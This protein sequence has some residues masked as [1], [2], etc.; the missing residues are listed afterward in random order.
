MVDTD[1]Q[2]S[3]DTTAS[4]N[5]LPS[6]GCLLTVTLLVI[7][8]S[9]CLWI[10]WRV[11]SQQ[12]RLEYL[13]ELQAR[14][15][16]EPAKPAWLHDLVV[17]T[18]GEE[19]AAGLSNITSVNLWGQPVTDTGLEHLSGCTNLESLDLAHTQITDVGLQHL[20]GLTNLSFLAL[21]GTE[22]TDAGL[23][24]LSGLTNLE[25]LFLS[26]TQVSDP[27]LQHLSRLTSL[28]ELWLT[29][30]QIT[31]TGFEHLSGTDQ[32]GKSSISARHRSQTPVCST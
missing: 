26:D 25:T 14:F 17:A 2:E 7:L 3:T 28:K 32:P 24:H 31:G 30:T 16:A 12:A 19:Q 21:Y 27:G 10:R 20:T 1:S 4:R 22:V 13:Q 18:L 29:E 11:H 6:P 8:A 15:D 23:Q 9:V 5:W